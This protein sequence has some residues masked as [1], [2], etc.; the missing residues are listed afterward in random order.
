MVYSVLTKKSTPFDPIRLFF[1]RVSLIGDVGLRLLNKHPDWFCMFG[2]RP[3]YAD[4]KGT[5]LRL[6]QGLWVSK[7]F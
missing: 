1:N 3:H 5:C 2:I 7:W 6:W 4:S